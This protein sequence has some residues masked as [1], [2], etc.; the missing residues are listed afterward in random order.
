[1]CALMATRAS[2][3]VEAHWDMATITRKLVAGYGDLVKEKRKD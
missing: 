3:E 1:M 2:A